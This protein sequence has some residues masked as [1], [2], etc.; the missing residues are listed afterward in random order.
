MLRRQLDD[1]CILDRFDEIY[2]LDNIHAHSK[3]LL[4]KD[5]ADSHKGSRILFIGDTEHDYSSA[6][7]M[8]ADC[9]LICGGHQPKEKLLL[10]E[11]AKVY[12]SLDELCNELEG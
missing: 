5:F 11:G 6:K 2:G 1:L 8:G 3:E 4:A 10:C 9:A 12:S 7:L